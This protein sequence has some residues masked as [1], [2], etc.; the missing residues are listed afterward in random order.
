[1]TRAPA[2]A[3]RRNHQRG[4]WVR[5]PAPPTPVLM[6]PRQW[7]TP[8]PAHTP[9]HTCTCADT[10]DTCMH[11]PVYTRAHTC[12]DTTLHTILHA[13]KCI[14]V[15]IPA[16]TQAFMYTPTCIHLY[17]LIPDA[18]TC[19]VY[20]HAHACKHARVH[21]HTGQGARA[22][23][24]RGYPTDCQGCLPAPTHSTLR[25]LALSPS[26]EGERRADGGR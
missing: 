2:L 24:K 13:Y 18:Y 17:A 22:G 9:A 4:R 8:T 26:A 15:H 23:M 5:S 14:H 3:G 6:R 20:I 21:T 12:M 25:S 19:I 10:Q 16:G 1:M 11:T 7:E